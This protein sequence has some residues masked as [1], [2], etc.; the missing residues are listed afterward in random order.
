M[1]FL[2]PLF[3]L[4]G[5]LGQVIL[6]LFT[7]RAGLPGKGS[8]AV[9]GYWGVIKGSC[10]DYIWPGDPGVHKSCFGA[11]ILLLM[12]FL[13]KILAKVPGGLWP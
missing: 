2:D 3:P 6:P 10:Y 5:S 8:I 1:H 4:S 11:A 12:T 7:C 9:R 13:K